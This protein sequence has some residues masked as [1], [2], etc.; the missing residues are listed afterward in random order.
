VS[1]EEG[2]HAAIRTILQ[3]LLRL[4]PCILDPRGG[5]K[6][7][8]HEQLNVPDDFDRNGACQNYGTGPT[9]QNHTFHVKHLSSTTT[10]RCRESL[11]QQIANCA[12]EIYVMDYAYQRMVTGANLGLESLQS[13]KGLRCM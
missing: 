11:D 8:N 7:N 1:H 2:A 6:P 3:D 5:K 12:S 13:L 10:Q 4:L 9:D